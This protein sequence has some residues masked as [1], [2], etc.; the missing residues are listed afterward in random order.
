MSQSTAKSNRK[1]EQEAM[2]KDLTL[3]LEHGT[4]SREKTLE[5]KKDALVQSLKGFADKFKTV[6]GYLEARHTFESVKFEDT[7]DPHFAM[8][9]SRAIA[10]TISRIAESLAKEVDELSVEAISDEMLD[11]LINPDF[12][13]GKDDIFATE[14]VATELLTMNLCQNFA[15]AFVEIVQFRESTAE[16]LASIKEELDNLGKEPKLKLAD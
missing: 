15:G 10:G 7:F 5:Y 1:A 4:E 16:G 11:T 3:Q 8:T 12:I 13:N 2:K 6:N 14:I 9:A